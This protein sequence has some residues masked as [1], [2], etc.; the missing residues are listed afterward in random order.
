MTC[1]LQFLTCYKVAIYSTQRLG[2]DQSFMYCYIY[3]HVLLK[4]T[5]DTEQCFF[6]FYRDLLEF[7]KENDDVVHEIAKRYT[8]Y[9][10]YFERFIGNF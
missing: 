5:T 2:L 7:A 3:H 10:L 1:G 8:A 4:Y 6:S 9:T